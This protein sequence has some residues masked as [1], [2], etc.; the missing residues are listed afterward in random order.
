MR[1][2]TRRKLL[3]VGFGLAVGAGGH[4]YWRGRGRGGDE[5]VSLEIAAMPI[6]A[7]DTARPEQRR[8]GALTYRS[9]LALKSKTRGFGGFSALWRDPARARIVTITDQGQ[10]FTGD[11][12]YSGQSLAGITNAR[13][14]PILGQDGRP[15]QDGPDYDC[16]SLAIAGG[17]AFIGIERTHRV[18]RF[19]WAERG[20]LARGEP[21]ELLEAIRRQP[22]NRGIEALCFAPPGHPLAGA[23]LAF[24][25]APPD[26]DDKPSPGWVVTGSSRFEF[27]IAR[28]EEFNV[29]DALFLPSGELIL[30]ER[31]YSPLRGVACRIRRIAGDA[32]RP[33]AMLDGEVLLQVD[34]HFEVDN[35]EGIA[36]HRDPVSGETILTLV[37]DD[38][39]NPVQRTLLLEFTLAG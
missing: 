33:G 39:F 5:P 23:L 37:S 35:M 11:L 27:H 9:G 29:T 32:I 19:P 14:A 16:E 15:L 17:E 13:M 1:L 12:A 7:F 4:A 26:D 38:N 31:S 34:R 8:F 36:A 18:L 20:M 2:P 6:P 21:I 24:A 28:S 3:L 22:R 30:L 10:W 25:E